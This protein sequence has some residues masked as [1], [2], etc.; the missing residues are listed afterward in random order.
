MDKI[1]SDIYKK[2]KNGDF[3]S[4]QTTEHHDK[5]TRSSVITTPELNHITTMWSDAR[6]STPMQVGKIA[7]SISP[8]LLEYLTSDLSFLDETSGWYTRCVDY[9]KVLGHFYFEGYFHGR[10]EASSIWSINPR[11]GS[12]F[13]KPAAG[14]R[15]RAFLELIR[16]ENTSRLET[17]LERLLAKGEK[18]HNAETILQ[19]I[20]DGRLFADCAVQVHYGDAIEPPMRLGWHVDAPNSLIHMAIALHGRRALHSKLYNVGG[21]IPL[22]LV[23]WQSPG[24]VYI[25]SPSCFEHA[26]EYPRCEHK[27]RVIAIQ[28]RL[29]VTEDELY[30]GFKN[31]NQEEWGELMAVLAPAVASMVKQMPTL[32]SVQRMVQQ[33]IQ[34]GE[35]FKD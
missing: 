29:L 32:E 12:N 2:D 35:D 5:A 7:S 14:L 15:L 24:D 27:D 1:T 10:R 11:L 34:T 30:T 3:T 4:P 23:E 13:S 26:V 21:N 6:G 16:I 19:L 9:P 31:S 20:R 8:E 28:S 22:H 33:M 18:N 17:V 25:T